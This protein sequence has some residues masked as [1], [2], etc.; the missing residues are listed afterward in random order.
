MTAENA[1]KQYITTPDLLK[2]TK[3]YNEESDKRFRSDGSAQYVELADAQTTRL[4]ELSKDPWVDHE[5]LNAQSSSLHDGDDVR[6]LILGG[7]FSGLLH[8]VRLI[9]EGMDPATIRIV[10]IAG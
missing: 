9:E 10:D 2:L 1:S 5:G 7:G 6:F 3:R 4:S 8:A